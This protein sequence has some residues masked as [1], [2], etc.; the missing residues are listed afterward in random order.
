MTP[1]K[2]ASFCNPA[3]APA[4]VRKAHSRPMAQLGAAGTAGVRLR[5]SVLALLLA[6]PLSNAWAI[7]VAS[8][9]DWDSAMAAVASATT[10]STVTINV[11][12]GFTL[13]SSL[14]AI[15][16]SAANVTVNINGGGAVI[17]GGSTHQG[18][19][20]QG[21]QGPVVTIS[22]LGVINTVATGGNGENGQN[23]YLSSGLA[24][25]AGGG[26]GGGLGAGAGLLI[27][28]GANVTLSGVTFTG[29]AARGGTGG[30]GG[31]AQNTAADPVNGGN[32]GAGGTLNSAGAVGGGGA[33]G[34]GGH[35]GGQGTTGTAGSALGDGGGGGG[36]SG[37]TSS[38][39]YTPNNV[40]GA[41]NA[42]GATGGYGGD[43]VTNNAG[44]QG[45][46]AD[47][48]F[49]GKGGSAF[50]GAIYV[51]TGGSLTILDTGIASASVTGGAGGSA[52][53]GVGPSSF[54]GTAG[55]T[56][57]A[58]GQAIYISG[59]AMN[60]GVT[61]GTV[62]YSGTIGGTGLTSG[63]VTTAINKTGAGT[64]AL[65][66]INT[67]TGLTAVQAGELVVGD[68]THAT[69]VIAGAAT[70]SSGATVSGFGRVGS[71]LSN[72]GTVMGGSTTT[73]GTLTAASYSQDADGVL[74]ANVASGSS[75]SKLRV[76]G[77]ATLPGQAK[78]DVNVLGSPVIASNARLADVILAGTLISDGTF[79]V[80]DNSALFNFKAV[81]NGNAVD[82]IAA[83]ALAVVD[84]ARAN[85]NIQGLGSAAVL[86]SFV[87]MASTTG[88][89]AAVVTAL[90]R[91]EN[92]KDVSDAVRQTLPL[93]AG[94]SAKATNDVLHGLNRV[95]QSRMDFNRGLS[96]G[97]EFKGDRRV[98]A[99]PFGSWA[100]QS[101]RRDFAGFDAK[102][103]GM[104]IGADAAIHSGYRLGGAF[105]YATTKLDSSLNV[106]PQSNQINSYM[107]ATYGSYSLDPIT[108][109]DYQFDLGH[110]RNEGSR[111]ISFGGLNRTAKSKFDSWSAHAG[112]GAGRMFKASE[113]LN[114][115][116]S[117]R[118]DYTTVRTA[119]YTESGADSLS[120]AVAASHFDE[121]LVS[122]DVKVSYA[123]TER[124]KLLGNV[125]AGY[126][127]LN[128]QSESSATFVGGGSAFV[129][130]GVDTSPWLLRAGF[131]V[132]MLNDKGME[133]TMRYDTEY[134]GSGYLNQS[135][136]AHVR[137]P[138]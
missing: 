53:T 44:S 123:M 39:S 129:T 99:K 108:D 52:G 54:N 130:K 94:D 125:T 27:G 38:T 92:Q 105:T 64:L 9:S 68:D 77:T 30:N 96:S 5:P 74:R 120:L 8:Q 46:G 50:G 89:V 115:V 18:L 113:V 19:V 14:A 62:S 122:S 59:V 138:F 26:G 56:G 43:G 11:T 15:Q 70:V 13:N 75:Y 21:A 98:W 29:N 117:V 48:G 90:G 57:S 110:N 104:V 45:P 1:S 33:G 51:A 95:I 36:G 23:G 124:V 137:M 28:S 40:G 91:L 67:Y 24:Y 42:N 16:T 60:V 12:S 69:A 87:G 80:T 131:G 63:S 37:T 114:V 106:A 66:A 25:G 88:D 41:G 119:G 133:V 100:S 65:N 103:Q 107:L 126:D 121:L 76:T 22:N 71:L 32:G 102:T 86:D 55:I 34:T 72:S 82:L 83:P 73:V 79:L 17:D 31:T 134:R 127:L 109:L 47:G 58:Q 81:V 7:D 49:G 4:R 128:K 2:T 132:L 78:I 101:E 116:P 111:L 93:L 20:V 6:F 135:V 35:A 85:N 10:G 136:S 3:V 97:D 112:I 118:M 84:A 61:S